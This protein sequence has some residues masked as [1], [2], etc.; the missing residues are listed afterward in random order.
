[1]TPPANKG[2]STW[3]DSS[4][5]GWQRRRPDREWQRRTAKKR[6]R[7]N[8][9]R[10]NFDPSPPTEDEFVIGDRSGLRKL[11]APESVGDVVGDFLARSGWHDRL[12]TTRLLADWEAI[13]GVDIAAN[14]HPTR[15]EKGVLYLVASSS[16]WATQ[17]TWL[18]STIKEKINEA[19]GSHLVHTLRVTVGDRRPT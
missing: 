13:V 1:M 7:D 15:I 5:G 14:A 12:R 2:R 8:N 18:E 11:S 3:N 19:A 6:E 4:K 16:T 17:L 10:E 9:E